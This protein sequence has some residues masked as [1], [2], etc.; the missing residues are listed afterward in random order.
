[1]TWPALRQRIGHRGAFLLCVA[2]YD[3]FYGWYLAIGGAI[4]HA[5]LIP[6]Q[7]WGGLWLAAALVLF[8]GAFF[9]HD[10]IFF[11]AGILIKMVWALEY[12]RLDFQAHVPGDWLR[13]CYWLALAAAL[14]TVAFWP[15]PAKLTKPPGPD[16]DVVQRAR[17]A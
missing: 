10:A 7:V 6:E 1:M 16:I 17:D 3:L 11:A 2:A 15:E 5:P 4:E 12:F 8:A 9:R 14:V 13:G